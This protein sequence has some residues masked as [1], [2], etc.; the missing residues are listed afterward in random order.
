MRTNRFEGK[1][2]LLLEGV[3]TPQVPVLK[4]KGV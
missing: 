3:V 4:G 2:H 1:G